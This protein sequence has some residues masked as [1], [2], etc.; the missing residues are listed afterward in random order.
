M[1]SL[2]DILEKKSKESTLWKSVQSSL[3]VEEANLFLEEIFGDKI[4]S[5]A[6]A[7]FVREKVLTIACL[8]SVSA[9]EIR[10]NQELILGKINKKFGENT[11][12]KLRYLD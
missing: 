2:S 12:I 3:V 8:N 5:H 11:V 1:K 10:F 4:K 6:R 9:Q 7:V